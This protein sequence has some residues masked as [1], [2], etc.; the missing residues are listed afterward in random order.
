MADIT[1]YTK[2]TCPYSRR[3]MELLQG[4]GASLA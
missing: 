3:A 4:E 2:S 1:L